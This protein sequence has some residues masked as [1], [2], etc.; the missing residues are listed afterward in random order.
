MAIDENPQEV[1]QPES[2]TS[3]GKVAALV[4]VLALLVIGQ[5]YTLAK[6]SSTRGA[7]ESQQAAAERALRT[8]LEQQ[9]SSK[10]TALENSNAQQLEALREELESTAKRMGST[11]K[12]LRRARE[13]VTNLQNEQRQQADTLKQEIALKADQLQVGALNESVSATRTDLDSTKKVL[14]ETIKQLGMTRSEFGTLIARN[15]DEIEKLRQL[16]D[17]DYFEFALEKKQPQRVANVG[18][19]LKKANAKRKRFN[20]ALLA[21]DME[22]E[23][24][25]RT[26]NEP[27]FFYVGGSK[28]FYEL[29][30]NKVESNRVTGYISTPKGAVQVAS[31]M[32]GTR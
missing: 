17:R 3:A 27:V 14:E 7:L 13:M 10:L 5:I 2:S 25:D 29:V 19:V 9:F 21:D 32:E 15:H 30:V 26:I 18:L 20:L 23:K 28:R 24:K 31:R 12:E 8:Q 6:L 22:V 11:G 1:R 16:G 4:A